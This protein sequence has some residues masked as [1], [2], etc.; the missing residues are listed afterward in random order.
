MPQLLE[1]MREHYGWQ[2]LPDLRPFAQ[3]LQAVQKYRGGS[4][5]Y[6]EAISRYDQETLELEEIRRL[7]LGI[8][9]ASVIAQIFKLFTPRQDIQARNE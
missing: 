4:A 7:V 2:R 9:Q 6:Q 5:H 3:S 8:E 1:F